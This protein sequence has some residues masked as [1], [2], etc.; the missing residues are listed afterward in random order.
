MTVAAF[1]QLTDASSSFAAAD[2][3]FR[4]VVSAQALNATT[5]DGTSLAASLKTLTAVVNDSTCTTANLTDSRNRLPNGDKFLELGITPIQPGGCGV[6]GGRVVFY[7]GDGRELFVEM[8]LQ[9][10]GTAQLTNLA[11]KPPGAA[12]RGLLSGTVS[13]EGRGAVTGVSTQF[14]NLFFLVIGPA[15]VAEPVQL[16]IVEWAAVVDQTGSFF[17][18]VAPGDYWVALAPRYVIANASQVLRI[19]GPPGIDQIGVIRVHVGAG[20]ATHAD[21]VITA[22][23]FD[24]MPTPVPVTASRAGGDVVPAGSIRPPTTGSGGLRTGD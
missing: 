6:E 17:K 7:D 10:G 19:Q 8:V 23:S 16:A 12:T 18:V 15:N 22:A 21:V 14:N 9:P 24:A 11:P 5:Q 4:V 3:P 1:A 20:Q 13:V 2:N